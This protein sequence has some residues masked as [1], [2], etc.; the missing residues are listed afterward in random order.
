MN[1]VRNPF[2]PGAGTQPPELS[3]REDLLERAGVAL[4]RVKLGRSAKS[5]I[6][7]GL[8]GV[9]KTALLN[10]IRRMADEAGFHSLAIEAHEQKPLPDLLV[11]HLRRLLLELDRLGALNETVKRSLRIFASFMS[12]IK[13]KLGDAELALDIDPETGAADS[14]DLE[15]DL[16]ELFACVGRAARARNLAVVLLIDEIQ[17]LPERDMGALIMSMHRIAQDGLP[18][19]LVAAGLPQVVGLSGRSKSYAE[20]LF[21]FPLVDALSWEETVRALEGPARAEPVEFEHAALV[22]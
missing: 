20:R 17:Y 21:D 12:S 2:V 7:V 9:G 10:R 19:L 1:P 8:R 5:F 13:L 14:G 22:A 15:A 4:Q 6:A 11:P 18:V 3:G 16:P